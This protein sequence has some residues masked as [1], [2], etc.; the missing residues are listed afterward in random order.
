MAD[1]R[2]AD[3]SHKIYDLP[4]LVPLDFSNS[5]AKDLT[6]NTKEMTIELAR[7]F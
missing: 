5:I 2:P 1:Y 6:G 3:E 4:K 7:Y